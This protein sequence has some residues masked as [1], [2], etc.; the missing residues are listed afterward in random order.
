MIS[1]LK[2]SHIAL[3]LVGFA[4]ITTPI[5]PQFTF[6]SAIAQTQ[7]GETLASG[8]FQ[9]AD[10]SH[11][12]SGAARIMRQANGDMIVQ[13]EN[14]SVTDGPDLRVWITDAPEIRNARAARRAN[15]V[16]LGRLQN[17]NGNQSYT[18]P[19]NALG[20]NHR[21]IV[22]WCRA[23]GVLFASASLN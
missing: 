13:L 10:R 15:H 16:D 1:S 7:D 23:F 19:A 18:I 22:I 12:G 11:R 17:S 9:D 14:F 4:A 2:L 21:S 6:S 3:G 8:Q 5:A 20:G